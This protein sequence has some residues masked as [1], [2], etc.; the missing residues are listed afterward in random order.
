MRP[1]LWLAAAGLLLVTSPTAQA[2][3]YAF[4]TAAGSSDYDFSPMAE[5]T[6]LAL[7]FMDFNGDGVLGSGEPIFLL[8]KVATAGVCPTGLSNNA[9]LMNHVDGRLPGTE[10]TQADRW[11]GKTI[12]SLAATNFVR[13]FEDGS[14]ASKLDS[15]DT[16]YI[17]LKAVATPRVDVGDLRISAFGAIAGGNLVAAGDADL[18]RPLSEIRGTARTVSTASIIY[19]AGSAY[20]INSDAGAI[21]GIS[22]T[23]AQGVPCAPTCTPAVTV[24]AAATGTCTISGLSTVDIGVESGD[25]R[26]NPKAVNPLSDGAVI[27]TDHVEIVQAKV[28]PGQPFQVLL[29]AKNTG[30]ASGSGLLE[31][32][33]GDQLV[34]S[35]GTPTIEPNGVATL[36]VTLLAPAT[37]GQHV[38]KS[39]AYAD[40]LTV[41]AG[42]SDVAALQGQLQTLQA[43]V[44]ALEGGS[45]RATSKL[46]VPN[47][48]PAS[49][50]LAVGFLAVALRSKA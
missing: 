19:K 6:K 45:P 46:S 36:V 8:L 17:D 4:G 25:I 12:L 41:T 22:C 43:Q 11:A 13:Y 30:K 49:L 34:D 3:D 48:A 9:L 44:A 15:K 38:V 39:G 14:D 33:I 18:N 26:L 42:E 31:T 10:I 2:V 21:G 20:Y 23:G 24:P 40:F 29:V 28:A 1:Y 5:T 27:L 32:R 7:C 35:R 47:A 50:F 16:V 37:P